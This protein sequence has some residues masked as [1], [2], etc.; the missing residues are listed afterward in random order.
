MSP[1]GACAVC[2][3]GIP[4]QANRVGRP[5]SYCSGACR[6]RAFRRR[7]A[8][9]PAPSPATGTATGT[10]TG[11]A[12]GPGG[13]GRPLPGSEPARPLDSF[14]GRRRELARLRTLLRTS[15]LLTLT[16]PGGAGKTRLALEFARRLRRG[17]RLARLDSVR[18]GDE[19]LGA[20]A[21]ALGAGE[22]GRRSGID[23][24]AH[25]LGDH[26]ALLVLDNCEHL[27][28]ECAQLAGELLG[29]CPRLRIVATSREVL[30]V[31]GEVVLRVGEL[32]LT[33]TGT[34]PVP[35]AVRLFVERAA[36]RLP[37]FALTG[38]NAAT[39]G[40]ICRRLDGM[41]LAIELAARRIGALPPGGILAGLDDQL[42]LLTDGSR[43][44]PGRHR[45]LSAVIDW[46]HRLLD[47][48]EQAVFRRLS[49]LAGGF[50]AE[51]A[52]AVCVDPADPAPEVLRTLCALEDK[53]LLVRQSGDPDRARFRQLG[54]IRAYALARLADSGELERTWERAVARLTALAEPAP[55]QVFPDFAQG[56]RSRERE[57]LAA[58][59]DHC[60]S[61]GRGAHPRLTIALARL[62]FSEERPSAA[63]AL[64]DRLPVRD[65]P[66]EGEA[67]ALASRAASH[68]ADTVA[69][70]RLAG[71]AV[72]A[73]RRRGNPAGLADALNARAGALLNRQDFAA[74]VDDFAE[75]LAVVTPLGRPLDEASCRH[76]LAWALLHTGAAAEA[77]ALMRHCLPVLRDHPVWRSTVAALHTA[78]AV[79][80][81]LDD[82]AS[83]GELFARALRLVPGMSFHALYPLEG[84]AV[85]AAR[86][87]A[88]KRSLRL[89]AAAAK[90]RARLD[91]E[92]EAAWRHRIEGAMATA[93]GALPPSARDSASSAGRRLDWA[94]LVAYALEVRPVAGSRRAG[95]V[96][97]EPDPPRRGPG[98]S[99]PAPGARG[100]DDGPGRPRPR[101]RAAGTRP[102]G[103]GE[104]GAVSRAPGSRRPGRGPGGANP[105]S[106]GEP[107]A[108]S[109]P[110]RDT[111]SPA[112][113][114]PPEAT[115]PDPA[116]G[117]A[118]GPARGPAPGPAR[119]PAPGPARKPA[120]GPAPGPA[121][122]PGTEPGTEPATG[123][124][125]E[126][127][128]H[129]AA[130]GAPWPEAVRPPPS[131]PRPGV[132]LT[133]LTARE[134]TVAGLV[135]EGLTN[136]E[137]AGRLGVSAST[138][139]THLDHVR[140]K[141]GLRSRTQIALWVD[142]ARPRPAQGPGPSP[143]PG[144][145][146]G[147]GPGPGSGSGSG[148]GP[149]K[150]GGVS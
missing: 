104:P 138:V 122:G 29:R 88:M 119:G 57:N 24:L 14:V 94:Q 46:S 150:P 107:G 9:S 90:A 147:P 85:V 71:L 6:Q 118:R 81:A 144:S 135:A 100:P 2:G 37:G 19:L 116:P 51:A 149:R 129:G 110:A 86:Q 8:I 5:A 11:P 1:S 133:P 70:L 60:A 20:V 83:A 126:P 113:G 140:D 12:T 23:L 87:G 22:R 137:V 18:T 62:H 4:R 45:E 99:G 114:R 63:R 72:A 10:P 17:T 109:R 77:D 95:R 61:R 73:E 91:T 89:F 97:G 47:A 80:L 67:Y 59:V 130:P 53:S 102:G 31:P 68:Q 56:V 139:A 101:S 117:P 106:G 40:E 115:A 36:D 125:Q 48:R 69:A 141:L 131:G 30:R 44:G 32:S 66:Y 42:S 43:T 134:Y 27:A 25:A 127:G 128:G 111:R 52:A 146:P 112:T 82:D 75:C 26:P 13:A 58:A 50:D 108:A 96:P 132:A 145:S 39:V 74:A 41:P 142:R 3:S 34:D 7:A 49:V 78:G 76:H 16:G 21:A 148:S 55:G 93:A 103:A 35:D 64:L 136:R 124:G 28:E 65:T 120:P 92:P 105:E 123:Q 84:L 33:A 15:R 98:L 54:A 143:S 121:T 79:R 38:A